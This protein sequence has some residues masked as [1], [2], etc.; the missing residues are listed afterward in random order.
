MP[1]PSRLVYNQG[2]PAMITLTHLT[3]SIISISRVIHSSGDFLPYNRIESQS[4]VKANTY[5]FTFS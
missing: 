3:F 5:I 1:T 4:F 2:C